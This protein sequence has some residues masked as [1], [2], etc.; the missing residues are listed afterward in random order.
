MREYTVVG[1]YLSAGQRHVVPAATTN[2]T[3]TVVAGAAATTA[4]ASAR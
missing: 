4:E 1:E 2:L 3:I